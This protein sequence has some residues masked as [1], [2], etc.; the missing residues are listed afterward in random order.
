MND[1][2]TWLVNGGV[3][4]AVAVFC[5]CVPLGILYFILYS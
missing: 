4:F 1:F 2:I 5:M 3:A